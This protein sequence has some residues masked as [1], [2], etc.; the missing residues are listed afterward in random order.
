MILLKKYLENIFH[1]PAKRL[2]IRGL[3]KK[4]AKD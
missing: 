3:E 2:D 4:K 1:L